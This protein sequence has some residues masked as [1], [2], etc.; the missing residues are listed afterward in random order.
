MDIILT[1][2]Y[3]LFFIVVFWLFFKSVNY[4]ENI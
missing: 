3:V 4:F 2:V 1:L